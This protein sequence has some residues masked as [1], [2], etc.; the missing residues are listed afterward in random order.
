MDIGHF[1]S[2]DLEREFSQSGIEDETRG[3]SACKI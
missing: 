1:M 2:S 3:K